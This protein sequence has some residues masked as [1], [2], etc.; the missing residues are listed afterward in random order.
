SVSELERWRDD[1][2]VAVLQGLRGVATGAGETVARWEQGLLDAAGG[3]G[4]ELSEAPLRLLDQE[5]PPGWVDYN[6]HVHESRYLQLFADAT[7]ALLRLIG[8][9]A[10]YVAG[11]GSFYTVETHL[12]HLAPAFAGDRVSVETHVLG[13]DGRRL[14][15][16]HRLLRNGESEPLATA[17]Q[18]MLHVAGGHVAAA[19]GAVGERA[20]E[21]ALLHAGLPTPSRA[22]RSIRPAG[23]GSR[24][25]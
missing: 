16:F 6:H 24:S 5:I 22:G 10:A 19:G 8:V 17:E 3:D 21:V 15:L 4:A 25:G 7:D 2:L 12:C 23:G 14:H 18:M 9:D 20:A 1:C 11:T 13:F